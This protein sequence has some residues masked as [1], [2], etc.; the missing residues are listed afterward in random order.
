MPKRALSVTLEESNLLWLKG[1]AAGRKKRS[2][3][4]ALDEILTAARMGGH[5]SD[6][7]RSVVDTVDIASDDETLEQ[8]DAAVRSLFEASFGAPF[9]VREG[10]KGYA[11]SGRRPAT[12]KK[13]RG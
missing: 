10:Q 4:D 9:L 11:G 8:A 13:R 2:L 6:T 7:I 5:G 1:R 3:S 12:K